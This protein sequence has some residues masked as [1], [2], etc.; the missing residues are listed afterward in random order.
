LQRIKVFARRTPEIKRSTRFGEPHH[1]PRGQ[2]KVLDLGLARLREHV[3]SDVG[4]STG[5]RLKG[6]ADYTA[7]EQ[8]ANPHAAGPPP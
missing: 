7:L 6:T 4:L 3:P 2:V 8:A 5:T 1:G